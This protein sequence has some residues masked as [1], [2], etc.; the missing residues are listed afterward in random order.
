[1]SDE[2]TPLTPDAL[3]Q[4]FANVYLT[5]AETK[6]LRVKGIYL[7]QQKE[8]YRDGFY[9][10]KLK[11]KE[12]GNTLTLKVPK[13]EKKK[14]T[15]NTPYE[16]EGVIDRKLA[17]VNKE[18]GIQIY[19][20]LLKI[21][22]AEAQLD[23]T[24]TWDTLKL[25]R[26]R[27]TKPYRNIDLIIRACYEQR[28]R[29]RVALIF[30]KSALTDADVLRSAGEKLSREAQPKRYELADEVINIT[31][32]VEIIDA[33]RRLDASN[34]YDLIAIFRGGG[35]N[36]EVF[37][38]IDVARAVLEMQTPLVTAVGHAKNTPLI[39]SLAD[40][41]FITPTALGEYLKDTAEKAL[42]ELSQL[43]GYR[44][45][46][47]QLRQRVETLEGGEQK[48]IDI[49]H[50]RQ[51]ENALDTRG[52]EID[53]SG[54]QDIPLFQ[55]VQAK[56]ARRASFWFGVGILAGLLAGLVISYFLNP[57]GWFSP[58]TRPAI[59]QALP[60]NAQPSP[61]GSPA[62]ANAPGGT[63]KRPRQR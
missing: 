27:F 51:N 40:R 14:L 3:T 56:S 16:L 24:V 19:F 20:R 55:S 44:R 63:I 62:N 49:P 43:N 15:H 9:Y 34:H 38:D 29:P 22:G 54:M 53:D 35:Q 1:M 39:E 4:L 61:A 48:V 46:I 57:F 18:L 37:D 41:A 13:D 60:V 11:D 28:R 47:V 25:L 45:E 17:D 26:A 23:D 52:L 21:I 5:E 42:R 12:S 59:Q 7:D 33:L 6:V 8:M 58:A 31:N 50:D 10:D 32:K 30:G 36:L 2:N